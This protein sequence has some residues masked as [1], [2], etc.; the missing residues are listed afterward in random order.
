MSRY[1]KPDGL[2]LTIRAAGPATKAIVELPVGATV[3]IR[4][5]VGIGWPHE[6]AYGKDVVV[7]TG[8]TGLAP[9]RPL[10]DR[11]HRRAFEV[12]RHPA[13][14]RRAHRRRHAVH[15]GARA[16]GHGRRVRQSPAA[17][18]RAHQ[19]AGGA[20]AGRSTVSA[21]HHASWDGSNTIAY[22]CGPERMMEATTIALAGRG[23][24]RD[25]VYV[26]LERH[27][28]C[29]LGFC[30]HCQ[31]GRFFICRDGPVFRLSDLGDVFGREGV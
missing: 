29:G 26:T 31:M 30:G 8:G 21:I 23:V 1:L 16:L 25:R 12:R 24:T 22:V 27:M 7:V 13:A 11:V 9:L 28:E 5:P 20:G 3:G 14:L 4:G 6:P 10:L 17:G 2:L 15:R 19:V 18:C